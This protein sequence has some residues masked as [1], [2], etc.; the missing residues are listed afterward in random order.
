MILIKAVSDK[1]L[2]LHADIFAHSVQIKD[3]LDN[4]LAL[5]HASVARH[6]GIE[7]IVSFDFRFGNDK[8]YLSLK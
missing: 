3:S 2:D 5:S 6:L 7:R 1:L 4:K 8:K